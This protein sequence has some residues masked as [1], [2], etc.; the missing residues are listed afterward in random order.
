APGFE[1]LPGRDEVEDVPE[2]NLLD[3]LPV[4]PTQEEG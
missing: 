4:A 1:D 2:T 3:H